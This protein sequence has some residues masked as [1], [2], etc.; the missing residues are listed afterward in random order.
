MQDIPANDKLVITAVAKSQAALSNI[1]IPLMKRFGNCIGHTAVA[2][3]SGAVAIFMHPAS[4]TPLVINAVV[5]YL[6]SV[7]GFTQ[8]TKAG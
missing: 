2:T 4:A 8:V 5:A 6:D 3:Q 1:Y 7:G